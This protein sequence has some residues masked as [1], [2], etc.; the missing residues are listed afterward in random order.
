MT[1]L[2]S[3]GS[4]EES[5]T[6]LLEQQH[7]TGEEFE[8]AINLVAVAAVRSENAEV[9]AALGEVVELLQ[10]YAD[11]HRSL[12]TPDR[13][14]LI[15]TAEYLR[16]LGLALSRSRLN[17]MQ[18]HLV[19]AADSLPMRS[20]RCRRLGVMVHELITNAARHASFDGRNAQIRVELVRVGPSASCTV[21]DNGSPVAG[22]R[23]GRRLKI[24]NELVK[25]LAGRLQHRFGAEGCSAT[26]VFPLTERELQASQAAA[27]RR[28]RTERRLGV[29]RSLPQSKRYRPIPTQVRPQVRI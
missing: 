22:F 26:L 1:N 25:G 23:P 28:A 27:A 18:I 5:R 6:L 12:R 15:D 10:G 9:K 19:V 16:S 21:S 13:D 2:L 11:V 24:V 20:D 17:R 4:A 29:I 8:S 3:T 14:V 7:R